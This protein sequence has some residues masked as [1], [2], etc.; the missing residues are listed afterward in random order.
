MSY[1]SAAR[2]KARKAEG[3]AE[4]ALRKNRKLQKE[5]DEL[6]ETIEDL[7]DTFNQSFKKQKLLE[8]ALMD[9]KSDA[10]RELSQEYQQQGRKNALPLFVQKK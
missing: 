3:K 5:L 4:D 10:A 9:P 7:K 8:E 2:S 6:K 1:D